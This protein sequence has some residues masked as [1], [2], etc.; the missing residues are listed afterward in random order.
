MLLAGLEVPDR[1]VLDLVRCLRTMGFDDTAST[2]QDAYDETLGMVALD[3]ADREAIQH[4]L[5]DCPFGLAELRSVM[6]L[7]QRRLPATAGHTALT[8]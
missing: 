3:G 7:E 4:A 5:A 6:L 8:D 1:L 2:L